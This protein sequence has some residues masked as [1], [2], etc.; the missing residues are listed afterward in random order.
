[1]KT[2]NIFYVIPHYRCGC[3]VVGMLTALL[4]RGQRRLKL[5]LKQI[6]LGWL[7]V[8]VG[9]ILAYGISLMT[10]LNNTESSLNMALFSAVATS[11]F[12]CFF[13]WIIFARQQGHESK[14]I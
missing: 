8:T 1:M 12:C 3:Y 11:L 10:H 14:K 2:A 9:L 6:Q 13:A 4:L 7:L 5:S